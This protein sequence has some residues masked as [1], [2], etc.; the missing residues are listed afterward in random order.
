MMLTECKCV[1]L[2]IGPGRFGLAC[3]AGAR[4]HSGLCVWFRVLLSL[5]AKSA[6]RSRCHPTSMQRLR[7]GRPNSPLTTITKSKQQPI[8]RNHQHKTL[9]GSHSSELVT[10]RRR[11]MRESGSNSC[12]LTLSHSAASESLLVPP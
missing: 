5:L 1:H 2:S 3:L 11:R 7:S 12:C 4:A 9:I 10:A 8:P 6:D